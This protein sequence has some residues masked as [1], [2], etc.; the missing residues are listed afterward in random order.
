MKGDLCFCESFSECKTLK[1][2]PKYQDVHR[3]LN[4]IAPG[5][6][7]NQDQP[8]TGSVVRDVDL[9]PFDCLQPNILHTFCNGVTHVAVVVVH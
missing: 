2:N 9:A 4:R 5:K 7:T 1:S 6:S 3:V 8:L